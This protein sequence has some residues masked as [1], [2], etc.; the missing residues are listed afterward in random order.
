MLIHILYTY[1][2]IHDKLI[3]TTF[4][5]HLKLYSSMANNDNFLASSDLEIPDLNQQSAVPVESQNTE[6]QTYHPKR[7]RRPGIKVA[8]NDEETMRVTMNLPVSIVKSIDSDAIKL[9]TTRTAI[10]IEKL[11]NY[12]DVA[13]AISNESEALK[14]LMN[15]TNYSNLPPEFKNDENFFMKFASILPDSAVA[16]IEANPTWA[17]YIP[18]ETLLSFAL[19]KPNSIA[20]FPKNIRKEALSLFDKSIKDKWNKVDEEDHQ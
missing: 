5:I 14:V 16:C 20:I 7:G 12:R 9:N 3:L 19:Q 6:N 13:S 2:Y 18:K 17:R 1:L 4:A 8:Q 10:I 15:G 11:S